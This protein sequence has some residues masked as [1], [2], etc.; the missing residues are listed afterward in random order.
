M[1]ILDFIDSEY[2]RK[3]NSE[4]SFTAPQKAKIICM[5]HSKSI[6][7]KISALTALAEEINNT[8]DLHSCIIKTIENWKN[9]LKLMFDNTNVFFT[10]NIYDAGYSPHE[11]EE[12]FS[13]FQ[14]AF[15]YITEEKSNRYVCDTPTYAIIKRI[16]PNT[17]KCIQYT[18]DNEMNL[19]NI[20]D[21]YNE[22]SEYFEDI[23]VPFKNGDIVVGYN[24][25]KSEYIGVYSDTFNETKIDTYKR[26]IINGYEEFN[27]FEIIKNPYYGEL[28]LLN[29]EDIPP[30]LN[31][32][33][34]ISKIRKGNLDYFKLLKAISDNTLS[35]FVEAKGEHI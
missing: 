5:N 14:H 13:H 27:L 20:S 26:E 23:D 3:L 16:I 6:H 35:Q 22:L 4:T 18:F 34:I 15:E 10:A 33:K 30:E 17:D 29:E 24:P 1:N 11:R 7:S 8:T 12:I 19:Y 31:I 21:C 32:L 28:S 2:L 9:A 25:V